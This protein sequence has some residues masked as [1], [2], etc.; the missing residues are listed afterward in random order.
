MYRPKGDP[1]SR[2]IPRIATF[3]LYA[4]GAQVP[5]QESQILAAGGVPGSKLP[6]TEPPAGYRQS[7]A[8]GLA[9]EPVMR[10]AHASR[11]R[12]ELVLRI[13]TFM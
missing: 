8:A 9:L 12:V 10:A 3:S 11:A 1:I 5:V 4:F 2:L 7:V 6:N 13:I